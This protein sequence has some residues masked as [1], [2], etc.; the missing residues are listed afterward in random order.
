[1]LLSQTAQGWQLL[2]PL[3]LCLNDSLGQLL[4]S[5]SGRFLPLKPPTS[6]QICSLRHL[7]RACSTSNVLDELGLL[8]LSEQR[9]LALLPDRISSLRPADFVAVREYLVSERK[10]TWYGCDWDV[11]L[12]E[13]EGDLRSASRRR[14]DAGLWSSESLRLA[15]LVSSCKQL[16][17]SRLLFLVPVPRCSLLLERCVDASNFSSPSRSLTSSLSF[18]SQST[19]DFTGQSIIS[20]ASNRAGELVGREGDE[21][22]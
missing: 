5:G 8:T 19:N 2:P 15:L 6:S 12:C 14:R 1:M 18:R 10:S 13:E 16:L 7:A 3:L 20:Y 4:A 22:D 21:N 17:T 11:D 9:D